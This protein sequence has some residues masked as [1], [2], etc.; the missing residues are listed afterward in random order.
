MIVERYLLKDIIYS[1]AT[2]NR[3]IFQSGVMNG[4]G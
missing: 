1:Q 2:N 3:M 4:H